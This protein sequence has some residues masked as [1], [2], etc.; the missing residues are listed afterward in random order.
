M[1]ETTFGVQWHL[2][3]A[4]GNSCKHCYID[5]NRKSISLVE[6]R[7][8]LDKIKEFT[9]IYSCHARIVFS[10]GDPILYPYFWELLS[11]TRQELPECDMI[12]L[13]NPEPLN[14]ETI[15]RFLDLNLYYY[16]VSLD[17]MREMHDYFRY[18]GSFV[19]T[20]KALK[21]MKR[22]GLKS[23]V[24]STVSMIN[25]KEMP[26]LV[27]LIAGQT[28]IYDFS[29]LVTVGRGASLNGDE[30]FIPPQA[31]RRFL[32]DMR[33]TYKRN[34]KKGT[35]FGSKEP[36]WTLLRYELGEFIPLED[37]E[38]LIWEGCNIGISTMTILENGDVLACR[39]VPKVIG[40]ISKPGI[41]IGDIFFDS[42]P[43]NEMRKHDKI[44]E[45]NNCK[46]FPYCRG[47]RAVARAT[48]GDFF[49]PDPQCWKGGESDEE[50]VAGS[51]SSLRRLGQGA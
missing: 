27:D 26:E 7:K 31:Y 9:E 49:S 36:L 38:G 15:Q 22:L 11:Y 21:R 33:D 39:R 32:L 45:C 41:G 10:G 17:G 2:T 4:C 12:V 19:K 1:V 24:M 44:N 35:R 29:R 37:D 28:D 42:T 47:C 14:R 51:S 18:P 23:A 8:I 40:N 5:R 43:L 25:L 20:V 50:G 13:G 3:T 6:A 48:N 30:V 46:L 16:Q 34:D